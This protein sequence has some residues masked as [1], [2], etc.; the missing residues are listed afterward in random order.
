MSWAILL[1]FLSETLP[2]PLP[3]QIITMLII[4]MFGPAVAFG[5]VMS[6]V[7]W[8]CSAHLAVSTWYRKRNP[9]T[10]PD[11]THSLTS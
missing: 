1:V 8:C 2:G 3:M 7:I 10:E 11:P 4:L 9:R 6:L 5:L